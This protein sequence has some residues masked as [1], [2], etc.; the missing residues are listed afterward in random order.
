MR[1]S[2]ASAGPRDY[3]SVSSSPLTALAY[4]RSTLTLGVRFPRGS[5]YLYFFVPETVYLELRAAH[6]IGRY[7]NSHI[8]NAG[9]TF[10]R[11]H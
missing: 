3:Q 8:R 1:G 10:Q 4:D 2:G 6:S 7:F 5:E 11:I 9:S